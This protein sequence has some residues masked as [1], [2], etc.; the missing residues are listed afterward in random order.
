MSPR[1]ILVDHVCMGGEYAVREAG[2]NFTV[3][4]LRSF[5][6]SNR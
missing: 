2:I 5:A 1:E 3:T 6:E 4:C